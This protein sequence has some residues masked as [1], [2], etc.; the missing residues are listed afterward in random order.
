MKEGYFGRKAVESSII[1]YSTLSWETL[2][3]VIHVVVTL[4]Y[5]NYLNITEN[6]VQPL[7]AT[8]FYSATYHSAQVILE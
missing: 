4:S 2:V 6:K 8:V 5:T 1:I 3:P 7:I